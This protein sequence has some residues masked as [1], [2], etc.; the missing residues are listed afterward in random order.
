MENCLLR[1][2]IKDKLMTSAKTFPIMTEKYNEMIMNNFDEVC[3][4]KEIKQPVTMNFKIAI[5][6]ILQHANQQQEMGL[7]QSA[8]YW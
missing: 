7:T 4:I 3:G 2:D 8:F 1:I 5:G 6:V